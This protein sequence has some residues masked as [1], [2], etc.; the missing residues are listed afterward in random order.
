MPADLIV[1]ALVAAGLVFWL[2]SVLGT[3]HEDEP[4]APSRMSDNVHELHSSQLH[5]VDDKPLS[6]ADKI[7]KFSDQKGVMGVSGTSAEGGLIAISKADKT[8]DIATFLEAAQDAFV[9]VVE[10]FADGDRET[11]ED[12][13]S[14]SVYE[15][16]DGAIEDR[17]AQGHEQKTDIHV[18]RKAEII[19][20]EHKGKMAYVTVRFEADETSASYDKNGEIL[21]GH[22]DKTAIMRDVWVFGRE[23][24]S[25]DPRWFVFETKGD[26]EGDNDIVPNSDE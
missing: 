12:L 25:N 5:N 3:R 4:Q 16:F 23:A 18:I 26:F 6:A 22:P 11:L 21:S 1:Y 10:A 17:E 19:E 8:F 14:P 24:K 9:I 7:T 13:L 2:R 20:A 15:A